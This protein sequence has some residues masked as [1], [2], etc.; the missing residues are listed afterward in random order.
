MPTRYDRVLN[1]LSMLLLFFLTPFLFVYRPFGEKRKPALPVRSITG[2]SA[3]PLKGQAL[4]SA[5]ENAVNLSKNTG[6]SSFSG[7]FLSE[8]DCSLTG[9]KTFISY[10]AGH[11]FDEAHVKTLFPDHFFFTDPYRIPLQSLFNPSSVVAP[12]SEKKEPLSFLNPPFPLTDMHSFNLPV[13][14]AFDIHTHCE[15]AFSY[16]PRV[17]D[18]NGPVLL[19]KLPKNEIH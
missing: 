13:V 15:Y 10:D 18:R 2:P 11:F 9:R 17:P 6:Y 8:S 3:E 19:F 1:Y 5:P 12:W 16:D 4:L 14:K 7:M